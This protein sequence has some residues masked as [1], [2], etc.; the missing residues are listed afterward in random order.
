[1]KIETTLKLSTVVLGLVM[2]LVA[3]IPYVLDMRVSNAMNDLRYLAEREDSYNK[4][5]SMLRDAES[6]QRGYLITGRE[7]YLQP[8]LTSLGMLPGLRDDLRN[9]IIGKAEQ[10]SFRKI[11]T[12]IDTKLSE[13]AETIQLRRNNGL[14]AAVPLVLSGSG[15]SQMTILRN[16]IGEQL[17]D[18]GM[19]RSQLRDSVTEKSRFATNLSLAVTVLNIATLAALLVAAQAALRK[20]Q[21]AERTATAAAADLEASSRRALQR[22]EQLAAGAQMMQALDLAEDMDECARIISTYFRKLLPNLSGTLYLYRNSRNALVR[23][24]TWGKDHHDPEELEPLDCWG[25]RRGSRHYAVDT[26]S[27]QCRHADAAFH[28]VPRLCLPLVTQGDVIGC[29]TIVGPELA[30]ESAWVEQLSEQVGLA[31]SNLQ[32]RQ[33]LRMQSI[34]DPLTELYNRRHMD[35]VLKRELARAERKGHT[36]SLVIVDLDHFKRVNDTYGHEAGDALL[37]RVGLLL[38]GSVRAC[39]IACRFGG[40]ELVLILPE[41]EL[42]DAMARAETIRRG[43]ESIEL[44]S[45][46]QMLAVSASLGVATT[47]D[48]PGGAE[49]L[50]HAADLAL[51]RAKNEGRNRVVAM[52][53]IGVVSEAEPP[54]DRH[55]GKEHERSYAR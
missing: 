31:F 52:P 12:A 16:L 41:C 22:N 46:G 32:L 55:H 1:M 17:A 49:P 33:T 2:S 44:S 6:G 34:V 38:R 50:L 30:A 27:L 20:R 13:M 21:L 28:D 9:K 10:A 11:D 18:Y 42:N 45:N 3:T 8:Y 24:A 54:S 23:K 4:L 15:R 36:L 7:E 29:I 40:E 53:K 37:R 14:D 51:Y 43:I 47:A 48:H 39:D 25:L 35:E 19:R 26:G 5:M